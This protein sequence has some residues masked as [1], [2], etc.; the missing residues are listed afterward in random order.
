MAST[1]EKLEEMAARIERGGVASLSA[2]EICW[3]LFGYSRLLAERDALRTE[4]AT[5]KAALPRWKRVDCPF[6]DLRQW[7]YALCYPQDTVVG[8][9]TVGQGLWLGHREKHLADWTGGDF[10]TARKQIEEALGLPPCE[11][12]DE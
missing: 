11:V 6:D 12:C 1:Q 10:P 9:V 5:V 4:L 3:L 7:G 2:S 8:Y